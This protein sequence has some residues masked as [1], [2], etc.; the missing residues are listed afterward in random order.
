MPELEAEDFLEL[1]WD[2]EGWVDLPAK[3][4]GYWI[5]YPLEWP[6]ADEGTG[7]SRRIDQSLRDEEDLYFSVARFSERGRAL[8]NVLPVAWLWADLD[9]VHPSAAA[10]MGLM[11]TIAVESS[12]GRYQAYW[13]LAKELRPSVVERLNRALTYA[14]GADKGGWDLTQVLRIPGTRNHKY[15]GAPR[16][17]LLYHREELVYDPKVV[18][19]IVKEHVPAAELKG[20]TGTVLPRKP[21]PRKAKQLLWAKADEVV[22]GERSDRLWELNC[23]LA[24]SGLDADEIYALVNVSV[25]NKWKGNAARLRGD[26]RKAMTHVRRKAV[27]SER[28]GANPSVAA[29]VTGAGAVDGGRDVA[30]DRPAVGGNVDEV[31]SDGDGTERNGDTGTGERLPFVSY[32]TFMAM[33]MEEPKW[34]IEDIW[35][36]GS[37]GF[38]GGEP[39][40]SKTTLALAVGLSVAS[41]EAF[42]GRYAVG[43]SGPVLMVQEENAPWMMQDR[44]R[45]LAAHSGLIST[46]D[47]E[48]RP[49]APG[50]LGST[51]LS[52]DMPADIPFWLLNNYGFDLSVEEHR[53]ML[54]GY[55]DEVRPVLLILDPMYLL[56]GPIDA[57]AMGDLQPFLKWII[58]LRYTYNC[59]V[60]IVHH[61]GKRNESTVGRRAGQR[62]LGSATLHGFTDAALYTSA[63]EDPRSGWTKVLIEREFR[64]M[65]PQDPVEMSWHFDRPGALGM[66]LEIAKQDL[67]GAI[68]AIVRQSEGVTVASLVKDLELDRRTILARIRGGD[69]MVVEGT[70]RGKI[71]RVYMASARNGDAASRE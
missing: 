46:R 60:M 71:Q 36:A 10:A 45:K 9:D 57:N 16:V 30:A 2:G 38:I 48:V 64:S 13:R 21:I 11:P 8:E 34:L 52:V 66:Q 65:E 37:H 6:P 18:W 28:Q 4:N 67:E 14:L 42:L 44:M 24:E 59:A 49:A 33:A 15:K 54:E 47:A 55:V 68:A 62:L 35:T 51:V 56:F 39:K 5:P 50:G 32:S 17:K 69:L 27:R 43:A 29:P 7:I 26:I 61:M 58:A 19:S 70:G 23:L 22:E 25:W 41:G 1:L 31:P 53:D 20:V 12:P 3:V 63:I 40:T